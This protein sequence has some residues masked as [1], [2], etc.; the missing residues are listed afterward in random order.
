MGWGKVRVSVYGLE[1]CMY[2]L[3]CACGLVGREKAGGRG[4]R[5]ITTL[6]SLSI[7]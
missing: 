6:F 5:Y 7:G 2:F 4:E 1:V 3:L